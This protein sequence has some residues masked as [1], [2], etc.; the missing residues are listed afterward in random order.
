MNVSCKLLFEMIIV[1]F[2]LLYPSYLLAPY[3]AVLTMTRNT[4][5]INPT[6]IAMIMCQVTILPAA[7]ER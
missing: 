5:A 2:L 3:I 7:E 1:S 6:I 4:T